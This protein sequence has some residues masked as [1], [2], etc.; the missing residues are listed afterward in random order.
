MRGALVI[1]PERRRIVV[2]VL[3]RAAVRPAADRARY[4]SATPVEKGPAPGISRL[5]N[6][7]L[8]RARRQAFR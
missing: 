3:M 7:C 1:D 8:K 6:A 2:D 4:A 5:S